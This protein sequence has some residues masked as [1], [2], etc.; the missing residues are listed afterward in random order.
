MVMRLRTFNLDISSEKSKI[1]EFGRFAAHD[2]KDEVKTNRKPL[3]FLA[4]L[5]IAAQARMVSS[6]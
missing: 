2:R 6:E 5:C 4:L 3:I 1:I